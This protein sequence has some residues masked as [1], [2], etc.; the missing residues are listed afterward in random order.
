MIL[1]PGPHARTARTG[2]AVR[3]RRPSQ[4]SQPCILLR[5]PLNGQGLN[6]VAFRPSQDQSED[7]S[8]QCAI[9]EPEQDLRSG[10]LW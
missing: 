1:A 2:A 5:W 4:P 7:H 8:G 10:E 9:A 3:V 6:E